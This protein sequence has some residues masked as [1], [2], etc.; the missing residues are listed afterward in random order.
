M[1]QNGVEDVKISNGTFLFVMSFSM[2][3]WRRE[4]CD[5]GRLQRP[6]LRELERFKVQMLIVEGELKTV[7][8]SSEEFLAD[9]LDGIAGK[10]ELRQID[11]VGED[12][13]IEIGHLV[14]AQVQLSKMLKIFECRAVQ[15][16][17]LIV[18]QVDLLD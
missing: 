14:V 4:E 9:G 5:R 15:G 3:F 12:G 10:V 6:L 2:E 18:R 11:H 7:R 16:R 8:K 1:K 17:D 13:A